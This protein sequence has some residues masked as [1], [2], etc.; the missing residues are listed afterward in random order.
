M[1]VEKHL[2]DFLV[3]PE[4]RHVREWRRKVEQVIVVKI[5]A[6]QRQEEIWDCKEFLEDFV[7][8]SK[9]QQNRESMQIECSLT[10]SELKE[11]GRL[12][13]KEGVGACKRLIR[14]P[15][16]NDA[17]GEALWLRLH[18]ELHREAERK[19]ED[20]EKAKDQKRRAMS[21]PLLRVLRGE[22]IRQHHHAKRRRASDPGMKT[23]KTAETA[24]KTRNPQL[25]PI[26]SCMLCSEKGELCPMMP[27]D[28]KPQERRER[29]RSSIVAKVLRKDSA[30][31]F[32]EK[33]DEQKLAERQ[34][35]IK[36][37]ARKRVGSVLKRI[38]ETLMENE[39]GNKPITLM[40]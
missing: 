16:I 30:G 7:D 33:T 35:T 12:P 2:P 13:K 3:S 22:S 11:L 28:I 8:K 15:V 9:W 10:F 27:S 19:Q 32:W 18:G 34:A 31:P 4:T 21:L 36:Y 1:A 6:E 26:H 23:V 25:W 14:V 24:G 5:K 40:D 39:D 29:R 37:K 38:G 17:I 20:A